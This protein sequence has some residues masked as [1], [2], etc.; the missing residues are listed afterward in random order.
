MAAFNAAPAFYNKFLDSF[1]GKITSIF[2]NQIDTFLDENVFNVLNRLKTHQSR[3]EKQ[4]LRDKSAKY[5]VVISNYERELKIDL[6]DKR[7]IFKDSMNEKSTLVN[8]SF[9]ISTLFCIYMILTPIFF[10]Y[11]I[12]TI[13][14]KSFIISIFSLVVFTLII[15][16][17]CQIFI[18]NIFEF[19]AIIV[20]YFVVPFVSIALFC[21]SIKYTSNVCELKTNHLFWFEFGTIFLCLLTSIYTFLYNV[22]STIFH[23]LKTIFL[24]RISNTRKAYQIHIDM[25]IQYEVIGPIDL[26]HFYYYKKFVTKKTSD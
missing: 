5:G 14:L 18:K 4:D 6:K 16:I 22:L 1:I 15:Q 17:I 20:V 7:D 9:I 13:C 2:G 19:F 25:D 10:H 11:L 23:S 24:I 8:Y 26:M 12:S 21:C 3:L